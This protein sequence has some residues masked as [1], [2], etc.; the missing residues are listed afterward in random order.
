MRHD[1]MLDFLE[2]VTTLRKPGG[3]RVNAQVL[4]SRRRSP[5]RHE[6]TA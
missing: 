1:S 2:G 3:H 4:F 6:M 5:A